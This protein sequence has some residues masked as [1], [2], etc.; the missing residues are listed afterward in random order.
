MAN[1]VSW[2]KNLLKIHLHGQ[3]FDE[4]CQILKR[5]YLGLLNS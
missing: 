4:F 3:L 5:G 2:E 1:T